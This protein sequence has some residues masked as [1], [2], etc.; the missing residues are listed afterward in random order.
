MSNFEFHDRRGSNKPEVLTIVEEPESVIT[1]EGKGEWRDIAYLIVPTQAQGGLLIMGRGV[2]VRKDGE[3]PFVV[4]Y[5]FAPI[6]P[7]EL[8]WVEEVNKRL[9]T[10]LNCNCKHGGLQCAVHKMY[11]PQW[12]R[13]DTQRLNLAGNAPLSEALE[14]LVKAERAAAENKIVVPRG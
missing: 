14:L 8:N 9:D 10:F 13:A 3:G 2:G 11:L 6:W 5:P 12:I 1:A 7:K 4:D